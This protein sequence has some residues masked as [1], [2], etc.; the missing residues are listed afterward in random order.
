MD[1][2]MVLSEHER[3][4]II[5]IQHPLEH[6]RPEGFGAERPVR[7]ALLLGFLSVLVVEGWMLAKL[8]F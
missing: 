1:G 3:Q 2:N 7:I 6:S 4:P 8:L 5:E